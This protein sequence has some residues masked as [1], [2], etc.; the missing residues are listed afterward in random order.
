MDVFQNQRGVQRKRRRAG[1]AAAAAK[2]RQKVGAAA[3]DSASR[4]PPWEKLLGRPASAATSKNSEAGVSSD[5][6]S[7][8]SDSDIDL[9]SDS[10]TKLRHLP[11]RMGPRRGRDAVTAAADGTECPSINI[12]RELRKSR[13]F[14]AAMFGKTEVVEG[15]LAAPGGCGDIDWKDEHGVTALAV[16]AQDGHTQTVEALLEAGAS[17][18]AADNDGLDVLDRAAKYGHIE[19]LDLLHAHLGEDIELDGA[20]LRAT[21]VENRARLHHQPELLFCFEAYN[22]AYS[23]GVCQTRVVASAR[24]ARCNAMICPGCPDGKLTVH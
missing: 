15:L 23:C 16:A 8:D 9:G 13:L 17:I 1:D 2:K 10:D 11:A 21:A 7:S 22:E 24:W 20:A 4:P 19:T 12:A 5:I 6:D 18:L 3:V 14:A